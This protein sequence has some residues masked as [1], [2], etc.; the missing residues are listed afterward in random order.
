MFIIIIVIIFFVV[1]FVVVVVVFDS[2]GA[3]KFFPMAAFFLLSFPPILIITQSSYSAE[4]S[5]RS[6]NVFAPPVS[7][8]QA[9][10]LVFKKHEN[11]TFEK[12]LR[13]G[14]EREDHQSASCDQFEH[15]QRSFLLNKAGYTEQDAPSRRS[16]RLRK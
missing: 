6:N 5:R 10:V 1:V 8:V 11:M 3:T 16:F 2:V 9:V 12:W 15:W 14:S 13:E 7:R 4:E